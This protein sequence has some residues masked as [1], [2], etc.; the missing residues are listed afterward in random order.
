MD[1]LESV[2]FQIPMTDGMIATI[3]EFRRQHQVEP[4]NNWDWRMAENCRLHC[5]EMARRGYIYY[6][7]SYYLE[8][9]S[10]AVAVHSWMDRWEDLQQRFIFSVLNSSESH[11]KLLLEYNCM[12]YAF[13]THDWNVY[14][15][16]RAR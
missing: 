6:A 2:R 10:E 15:T 11:R 14:L 8:G 9:W 13:W 16:I 12:A 1:C 5:L 3:N 7:E 4:V